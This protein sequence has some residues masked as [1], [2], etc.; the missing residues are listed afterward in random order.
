MWD[1]EHEG[2]F[3][4]DAAIAAAKKA[5]KSE[6]GEKRIEVLDIEGAV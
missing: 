4:I 2:E 5:Y 3:A 1:E 6:K